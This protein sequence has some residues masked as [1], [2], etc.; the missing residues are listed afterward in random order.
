MDFSIS[1]LLGVYAGDCYFCLE[2]YGKSQLYPNAES[3]QRQYQIGENTQKNVWALQLDQKS[4]SL[5]TEL[6][7]HIVQICTY[8]YSGVYLIFDI[9]TSIEHKLVTFSLSEV[10][11]EFSIISI[12]ASKSMIYKHMD[13]QCF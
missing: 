4:G 12:R 11:Y 9:P 8:L 3:Y 10:N 13:L 5:N 7:G 1:F 2:I 6:S